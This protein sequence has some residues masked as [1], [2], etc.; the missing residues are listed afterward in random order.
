MPTSRYRI[1]IEATGPHHT[2]NPKVDAQ[3]FGRRLVAQ[4]LDSGHKIVGACF[5]TTAPCEDLARGLTE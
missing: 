2:G 5:Q 3:V 4:L 1:E